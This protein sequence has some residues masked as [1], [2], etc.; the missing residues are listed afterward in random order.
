MLQ[1]STRAEAGGVAGVAPA[2]GSGEHASERG[3]PERRGFIDVR[4]AA[5][6]SRTE[7]DGERAWERGSGGPWTGAE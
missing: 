7:A 6:P 5:A 4:V 1:G 3:A 2:G